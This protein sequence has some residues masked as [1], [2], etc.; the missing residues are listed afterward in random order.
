MFRAQAHN[1]AWANYRLL[2]ACTQLSDADLAAKR[3]SFFPS[4]IH[5]LNHSLTV[6]WFYVS[7]LEGACAGYKVFEVE[8]PFA[9]IADLQRE[10]AAVDRRL[11][12][13]CETVDETR[14]AASVTMLRGKRTEVDRTDRVLLHLFQHQIHHRGQLH[15]MLAGT[16]VAPPQL[17]EFFLASEGDRGRRAGDFDALGF[18][19]ALIWR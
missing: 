1:N 17:D 15:A 5:T 13:V 4:I 18:N 10:Q 9:A 14:A 16:A 11:M 8:I 3:T 2:G 7:A 19:E 6:D 12:A